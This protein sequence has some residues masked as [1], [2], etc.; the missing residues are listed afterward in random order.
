MAGSLAGTVAVAST[1]PLDIIRVRLAFDLSTKKGTAGITRYLQS[2]HSVYSSLAAEGRTMYGFSL[3]GFYQGFLPTL[4]GILPYAGVSY[5]SFETQKAMY[6][7]HFLKAHNTEIPIPQK[8][9]MGMISG[10]LAQTVAYPLDVV[11]RQ[12]Q[13]LKVAPH[14]RKLHA[15]RTS[16]IQ[17]MLTVLRERGIKGLFAGLSINY[18]KVAPATGV[19]FVVYEFMRDSIFHLKY[20]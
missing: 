12:A 16:A 2:L 8:L 13:V 1:Y 17:I 6:R 11:R 7:D 19:S 9:L 10:A 5:F 14:L 3:A 20:T 4:G 18:L 15:G